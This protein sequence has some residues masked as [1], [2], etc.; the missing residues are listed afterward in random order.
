VYALC[1]DKDRAIL[2]S[3]SIHCLN[4]VGQIRRTT[5][6][7]TQA[8]SLNSSGNSQRGKQ[9]TRETTN[10]Y[11]TT[12]LTSNSKIRK[13]R[14]AAA[15]P[16]HIEDAPLAP[17]RPLFGQVYR[18]L[19]YPDTEVVAIVLSSLMVRVILTLTP[20]RDTAERD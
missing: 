14:A 10:E 4:D 7:A 8:A 9:Q 16:R 19:D 15:T 20:T 5:P 3:L 17:E 12:D 13:I 2:Q 1:K 11:Q 18:L 6:A